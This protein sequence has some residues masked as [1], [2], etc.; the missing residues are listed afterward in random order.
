MASILFPAG[1]FQKGLFLNFRT[2][3][4]DLIKSPDSDPGFSA[5]AWQPKP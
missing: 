3:G 4:S 1:A 5:M 2:P